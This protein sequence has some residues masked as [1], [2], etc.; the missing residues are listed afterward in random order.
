MTETEDFPEIPETPV[1]S[2][3][4]SEHRTDI[5]NMLLTGWSPARIAQFLRQRYREEIPA[6]DIKEFSLHVPMQLRLETSRLAKTLKMVDVQIDARLEMQRIIALYRMRLDTA[7]LREEA[8]GEQ[9][10]RGQGKGPASTTVL[11]HRAAILFRAC[12][13]Y[14]LTLKEI[15]DLEPPMIEAEAHVKLPILR[16]IVQEALES[17]K[18]IE[19]KV[20][21]LTDGDGELPG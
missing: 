1:V 10:E 21:E 15:G 19:G 18:T 2:V 6:E 9:L 5:F 13:E 11:E 20:K 16:E 8:T 17:G 12:K 7:D 3:E 14:L 4:R